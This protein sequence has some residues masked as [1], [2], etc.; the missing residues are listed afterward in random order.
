MKSVRIR[1]FPGPYY[2]AFGLNT[3]KYYGEIRSITSYSVGMHENTDPKN[4]EH[5]HFSRSANLTIKLSEKIWFWS[6]SNFYL[7]HLNKDLFYRESQ[8]YEE[9]I[10]NISLICVLEKKCWGN[11][12]KNVTEFTSLVWYSVFI[13]RRSRVNPHTCLNK[14]FKKVIPKLKNVW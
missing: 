13:E 8:D 5:G 3:E 7:I 14:L 2:P 4:S 9:V 1:T 12:E 11:L 10:A 6:N